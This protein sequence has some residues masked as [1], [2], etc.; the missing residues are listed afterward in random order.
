MQKTNRVLTTKIIF[1][2]LML[3]VVVLPAYGSDNSELL[4]AA[5]KGDNTAI[6]TL[7][8][9]KANINTRDKNGFTPLMLAILN[10]NDKTVKKL[11]KK[12]A[13]L[14]IKNN[15][16]LTSLT[17]ARAYSKNKT[18]KLLIKYGAKEA[19]W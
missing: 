7:L 3:T 5:K 13:D 17:L 1:F 19:V 4:I 15:K 6:E 14:N 18:I 2:C 8:E 16:G 9:A 10:C 11:V 12:G